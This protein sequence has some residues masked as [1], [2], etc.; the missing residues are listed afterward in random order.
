VIGSDEVAIWRELRSGR[1]G[2]PVR[3]GLTVVATLVALALFAFATGLADAVDMRAGEGAVV[4]IMTIAGAAWLASIAV[5]WWQFRKW[6]RLLRTALAIAG[7]WVLA[8]AAVALLD[9][10]VARADGLIAGTLLSAVAA[11]VGLLVVLA[12]RTFT[13]RAMRDELGGVRV[14]C[15]R[16]GYSM[17]GLCSCT[18]PECGAAFSI[19]QII[20]GQE[21]AL[22][23]SARAGDVVAR[24]PADA[25][26]ASVK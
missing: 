5:V 1:A 15:P 6:A 17:V 3:L 7:V 8:V 12:Y 9:V 18:C 25:T 26:A 14:S 2:W 10:N 19:D 16:C 20:A 24:L 21:Y 4:V 23:P 13:G 11:T 22:P